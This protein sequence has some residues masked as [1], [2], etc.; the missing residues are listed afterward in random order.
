MKKTFKERPKTMTTAK[1][2]EEYKLLHQT[3]SLIKAARIF[4]LLWTLL[5]IAPAVYF[6]ATRADGIKE[7]A[8][9]KT[10]DRANGILTKQYADFSDKVLSGINLEKYTAKIKVPEIKPEK[11][12]KAAEK[13][14]KAAAALSRLGIKEASKISDSS[15]AIQKQIDDVNKQLAK[16]TEQIKASLN[17]EIQKGLKKEVSALAETQIKKQLAL[18]GASYKN[19][20]DGKYGLT[21]KAGRTVTKTIYAELSG[22]KNGVFKDLLNGVEKYYRFV[23]YAAAALVLIALLIPPFV[24]MKL[25]KK[26]SAV[27]T[28]CPYC[29]KIFMTKKNKLGLL[30]LFSFR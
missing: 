1:N 10:I 11:A 2:G 30:K 9:V 20:T 12:E 7:F 4:F 15:A 26:F 3:S 27:F 28:Q 6:M 18:S 5:V 24:V 25:A 13:T 19:M 16:T 17:A 8:V 29:D 21:D 22:N 14:K 23:F